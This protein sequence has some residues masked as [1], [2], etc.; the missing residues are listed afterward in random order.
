METALVPEAKKSPCEDS[1]TFG[2]PE[3]RAG[4][5]GEGTVLSST[6]AEINP[7]QSLQRTKRD[8]WERLE[9]SLALPHQFSPQN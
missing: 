7:E 1:A 3:L 6:G 5:Y 9:R 4:V 8:T 2:C